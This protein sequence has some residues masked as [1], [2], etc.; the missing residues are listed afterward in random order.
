MLR[1]RFIGVGAALPSTVVGNAEIEDRLGV[2]PGW[3]EGRTGVR[4]RRVVRA[5]ETLVDLAEGAAR[6]ALDVA[7][8]DP[9]TLDGIV[10]ATTSAPYLFPSLA[11]LLHA[12][13]G[14]AAQPAF[15]VAAACAGFP[16]ALTVADQAIRAGDHRRVLVV[17]ADCLSA[18]CDPTDR[19]TTALFGDGAGAVVLQAEAGDLPGAP[20]ILASRLRALGS[21]WEMLYVPA[22]KR[23]VAELA[24][25]DADPWMR[26]RG[27]DVFRL[28]VEQLVA[29]SREVLEVAGFTPD[30]VA[31]IV[32]HQA[33]VRIIRM[34]LAQ[35]RIPEAR[36]CVNL[37]RCGNTSAASI[38]LA[39]HDAVGQRRLHPGDLLLLNAVGGGMTAG[40]IVVRW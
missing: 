21:Q 14:L 20:G 27:Q 40:A 12:R 31:L 19:V 13:L 24:A 36:A 5:D 22:G 34:M 32:P 35:L 16:Y 28:A 11:C 37:D 23:R 1:S 17:G 8:I 29:L 7:G 39:L 33:N 6:K 30:D 38:P 26:M 4:E 25:A 10:V 3:I 18:Y 2:E 15:D 9:A